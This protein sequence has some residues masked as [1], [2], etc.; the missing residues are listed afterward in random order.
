MI[1]QSKTSSGHIA[2][3]GYTRSLFAI[4]DKQ[5]VTLL[6]TP[7]AFACTGYISAATYH[8]LCSKQYVY[9][10]V[11]FDILLHIKL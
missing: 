9:C 3:V 11:N 10:A 8:Q 1:S 6:M 7:N 5:I 2:N 4:D